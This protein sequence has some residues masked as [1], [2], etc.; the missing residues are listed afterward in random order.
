[1]VTA[2][3]VLVA[4]ITSHSQ[5]PPPAPAPAASVPDEVLVRFDSP[6]DAAAA[7]N[8]IAPLGARVVKRLDAVD[9]LYLIKL[10]PGLD[11]PHARAAFAQIAGVLYAEP[12]YLLFSNTTPNDPQYPSLW[13]LHNTGQNGG[14]PGADIHAPEAWDITTGSS[15]VV[16]AV[17]DTGIDYTHQDLAA[18]MF[19]N[20]ADCNAN[21]V[22]DDGNGKVDDCYG[23]DTANDDSDPFDDNHH[24]THV[25][26][27]IGAAGNNSVGVVGVNWNVKLMACKFL[28]SGGSGSTS[29]AI[30]CLTYVAMM[31]DR[32][33]N[34]VATNN[35]WGGGAY[36]QALYDAIDAQRQR[37]ILFI[38]AAGNSGA[39][40][41]AAPSYPAG[42]DLP[43]VLA[44]AA[45]TRTDARPSFSNYGRQSVQIG[46]PGSEILSTFPGNSYSQLSGTSMAAPHVTG[47]AAL[48][49]AQDPGRDWRAIRNLILAGGDAIS[50]LATT[51][52]S[53][54]RLNAFG[55]LT[56]SNVTVESRLKPL[57]NAVSG[58]AG[59]P[60]TLRVVNINCGN[61]NGDVT[62]TVSGGNPS[63]TLKD[64][65]VSPDQAAGDGVYSG[66]FTPTSGTYTLTFP[67]GDTVTV[68]TANAAYDSSAMA[69]RCPA[70]TPFCSSGSLLNG[71]DTISGGPEPHQPNTINTSCADGTLGSYLSDES[72]ESLRLMTLDGGAIA[73]GKTLRLDVTVYA[74]D[75]NDQLDLYLSTSATSPTWNLLTTLIPSG[76][77]LQTLTTTFMAASAGAQAV[78]ANFRYMGAPSFCS[79]GNF[80]DHDDLIYTA[81]APFMDDSLSAGSPV[82]AVHIT[83]LRTRINA[84]RTARSLPAF[85]FT[86]PTLTPGVTAIKGVHITQL[87]TALSEAYAAAGRPSPTYTDPGL[88]AGY[89][90]KAVHIN[91]LR[92]AV[93]ALE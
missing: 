16:V 11:P 52:V 33:V 5:T 18:N 31:K 72:I 38:V 55:S 74:F 27:T 60:I 34:I 10:P 51:T 36:S 7:G 76:P 28:S 59:A 13:G 26:G 17:I 84:V 54:R 32:G 66:A 89:S 91:E 69:P 25:A 78:R 65:G 3:V 88:V 92:D 15:A 48:L 37:G 63:I 79:T 24:G 23:I 8:R 90:I 83:E 73:P 53:G 21:G 71:R 44:V 64:N 75:S 4:S 29:D 62:V 43:N 82:K 80:D 1:V 77:G 45:T 61:P 41:D 14:T 39:D 87:R 30:D 85:S 12:N 22:D 70:T 68:D 46:A 50:S 86:D 6:V 56:C 81:R 47:V 67:G 35:S 42:Y 9:G 93:V 20:E 58:P 40:N 49:K 57:T 19:R 2:L